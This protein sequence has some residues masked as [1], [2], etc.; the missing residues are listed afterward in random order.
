ME[1]KKDVEAD[2]ENIESMRY[3][4]KKYEPENKINEDLDNE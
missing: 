2:E 1:V 4:D 3:Y